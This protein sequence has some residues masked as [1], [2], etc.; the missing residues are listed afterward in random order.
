M[1]VL[2][3]ALTDDRPLCPVVCYA[4]KGLGSRCV[5]GPVHHEAFRSGGAVGD[6]TDKL[7]VSQGGLV[8][9][10]SITHTQLDGPDWSAAK[11]A[12]DAFPAKPVP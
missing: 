6:G 12:K 2:S 4:G 8:G 7:L 11:M 3:D 5:I 1:Y 10:C 9:R